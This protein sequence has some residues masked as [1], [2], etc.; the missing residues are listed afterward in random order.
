[1]VAN[2]V[3]H[4]TREVFVSSEGSK[5]CLGYNE[6]EGPPTANNFNKYFI[7]NG[8]A[9]TLSVGGSRKVQRESENV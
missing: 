6:I 3:Y 5:E 8:H 2:A 7:C 9:S 1:M 4:K